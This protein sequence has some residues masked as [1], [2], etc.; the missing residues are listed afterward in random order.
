M[1]LFRRTLGKHKETGSRSSGHDARASSGDCCHGHLASATGALRSRTFT[2]RL[3]RSGLV[4]WRK[5]IAGRA[6]IAA[7]IYR[8]FWTNGNGFL[9]GIRSRLFSRD[10]RICVRFCEKQHRKIVLESFGSVFT[11][12]EPGN[13]AIT[14]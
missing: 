2:Y 9:R 6:L 8:S 10:V 12:R 4:Y 13:L 11:P 3:P 14:Q 7:R 1:R 5:I